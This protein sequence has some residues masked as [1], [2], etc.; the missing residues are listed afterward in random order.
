MSQLSINIGITGLALLA[1]ASMPLK[2]WDEAFITATYL[3]NRLPT[4]VIDNLS[5]LSCLFN[6]PPN[7]SMLKIFGSVC[8]PHL[9]LY[10][11]HKLSF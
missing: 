1:H 10:M 3:I 2:F 5:P 4:R 11:K 6:T 9:H 8:W 7:Y